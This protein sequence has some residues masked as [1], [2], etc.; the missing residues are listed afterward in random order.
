MGRMDLKPRKRTTASRE[1]ET[2]PD[3]PGGFVL[4]IV[5]HAIFILSGTRLSDKLRRPAA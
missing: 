2:A 5:S 1:L 4:A 3:V